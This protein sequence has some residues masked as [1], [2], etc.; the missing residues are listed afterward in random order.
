MILALLAAALFKTDMKLQHIA[1]AIHDI[2]E[3]EKFYV[4]IL[5]FEI[6]RSFVLDK[7]LAEKIFNY[8]VSIKVFYLKHG[9]FE[10]EVF[11]RPGASRLC[12]NHICISVS[13]REEY[14]RKVVKKGYNSVCIKRETSD[15]I[16]ISDKC[17]NLFELKEL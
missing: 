17:N 10:L 4:N 7:T 1:I 14:Y 5:G 8:P 9:D 15:L 3:I 6:L 12:F 11:I 2:E 13:N 16:F